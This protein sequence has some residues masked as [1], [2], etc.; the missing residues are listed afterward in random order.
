MEKRIKDDIQ[1]VRN[2]AK[3]LRLCTKRLIIELEERN[4]PEDQFAYYLFQKCV[5]PLTW[6]LNS[7]HLAD[8]DREQIIKKHIAE[9]KALE[10]AWTEAIDED[11]KQEW[12]RLK[13]T[14]LECC[15]ELLQLLQIISE[16]E[17][18]LK[19]K[20]TSRFSYGYMYL[21]KQT[22]SDACIQ[23]AGS[24][25]RVKS[26]AIC[27][28]KV[29]FSTIAP[30][31]FHRG[32]YH[33]LSVV[34]Y[35]EEY[36]SAVERIREN[37]EGRVCETQSGYLSVSERTSVRI[38][39]ESPDP[40]V[41]FDSRE[42]QKVWCGKYLEF[43]FMVSIPQDYRKK[44]IPL[45]M[46]VYFDE[47][48]ATTLKLIVECKAETI[49]EI[50]PERKDIMSAFISYARKDMDQ[51]TLLVQGMEKIRPDMDIFV[52]VERLRSGQN[53]KE[54]LRDEL[55]RRDI[56][57]LCW[58]SN[59]RVSQWVDYEWRYMYN[60]RG[61]EGIDPVPLESPEICPP[62]MELKEKH[63]N[64]RWIKYRKEYVNEFIRVK[65]CEEGRL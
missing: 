13:Q 15:C 14:H 22:G 36:R 31:E 49:Q 5:W 7:V 59:A 63:F 23:S 27:T 24:T 12:I 51:I 48:A 4:G 54:K 42:E 18:E 57:Y 44:Q 6:F 47:L 58:S 40:S 62:P 38:T 25:Q 20:K 61:A 1:A 34:M 3:A 65:D 52:D 45:V 55:D 39:I 11:L 9:I 21:H 56:L 35:E 19:S 46:R 30:S 50:R 33:L 17:N 53:W 41:C 64:D 32:Q 8:N 16:K 28:S 60:Q 26:K 2:S 43:Q 29:N 10:P 37:F